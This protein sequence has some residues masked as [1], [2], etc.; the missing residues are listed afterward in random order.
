[1]REYL[2]SLFGMCALLGALSLIHYNKDG[3]EKSASRILFAAALI[4]P[5]FNAFQSFDG[6]LPSLPSYE[7]SDSGEYIEVARVAFEEGVARLVCESFSLSCDEVRVESTG[8]SFADMCAEKITITL[9]GR[10]AL[11]DRGAIRRLVERHELGEC[12]VRIS[13]G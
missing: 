13:V 12:E 6:A 3:K 9:S 4:L 8:F 11:A 2:F 5:L 1:M 10:A 7:G